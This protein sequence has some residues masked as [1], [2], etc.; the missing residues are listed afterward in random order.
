MQYIDLIAM[1][2][3]NVFH[4][5]LTDDNGWRIE[6]RFAD[7]EVNDLF[8][9]LFKSAGSVQDFKGGFSAEPRHAAG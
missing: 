5:H 6:I 4:W 9:L 8:A 3:M 1:Y 7:F 2:K